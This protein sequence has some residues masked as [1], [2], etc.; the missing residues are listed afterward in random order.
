MKKRPDF[1]IESFRDINLRSLVRVPIVVVYKNPL[2]YPDKYVARLWDIPS[3]PTRYVVIKDSLQDI[4]ASIPEGM[5]RLGRNSMEDPI[6][7]ET[8]IG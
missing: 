3:K 6:I 8:Y 5:Q 1:V 7:V 2:D 4:R